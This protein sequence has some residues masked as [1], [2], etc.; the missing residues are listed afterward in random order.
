MWGELKN[1][2]LNNIT[3]KKKK[4]VGPDS[5]VKKAGTM[6]K[7]AHII[8][9]CALGSCDVGT[10]SIRWL[11]S[12]CPAHSNLSKR[13]SSP[14]S[15]HPLSKRLRLSLQSWRPGRWEMDLETV[16]DYQWLRINQFSHL[17]LLSIK[18]SLCGVLLL[19]SQTNLDGWLQSKSTGFAVICLC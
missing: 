16:T 13:L 9:T 15:C 19:P 7:Q 4:R 12:V 2:N 8:L 11:P 5:N 10:G 1:N 17:P 14:P 3:N 18:L 6:F